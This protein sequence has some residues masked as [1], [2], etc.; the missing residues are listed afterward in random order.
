VAV[1]A[2]LILLFGVFPGILTGVLESAAV[3]RW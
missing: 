1:P 3:L 2:V